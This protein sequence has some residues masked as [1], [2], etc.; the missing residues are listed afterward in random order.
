[1]GRVIGPL[2][3]APS[4]PLFT[5][6]FVGLGSSPFGSLTSTPNPLVAE[7]SVNPALRGTVTVEFGE[8]TDYGM[9]TAPVATTVGPTT[10]LV[11][12]LKGNATNHMRARAEYH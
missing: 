12:G 11:A 7:Y 1:M 2:A 10:V 8:T 4:L 3:A 6:L 5:L 9:S